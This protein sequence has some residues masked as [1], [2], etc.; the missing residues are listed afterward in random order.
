M[1]MFI[2]HTIIYLIDSERLCID[3]LD[4]VYVTC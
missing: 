1:I 2:V 3:V 4:S